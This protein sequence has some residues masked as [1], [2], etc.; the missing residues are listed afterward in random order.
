MND[1]CET[2]VDRWGPH[3]PGTG[4]TDHYGPYD[5]EMADPERVRALRSLSYQGGGI[6]RRDP[7]LT[8]AEID[9]VAGWPEGTC[10]QVEA[11]DLVVSVLHVRRLG[12]LLFR[13][14]QTA[15]GC[16]TEVDGHIGRYGNGPA[17]AVAIE[18]LCRRHRITPAAL[19]AR[20]GLRP[21]QMRALA[22]GAT[23]TVPQETLHRLARA[24]GEFLPE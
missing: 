9:S 24:V 5:E 17:V 18:S 11:G 20:A 2:R 23:W 1:A 3:V 7:P 16:W 6:R 21:A 8:P 19:A 14:D 13:R 4:P 15:R 22:R 12:S 10:A